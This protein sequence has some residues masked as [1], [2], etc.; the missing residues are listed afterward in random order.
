MDLSKLRNIGII[1]HVDAGKTTTTE[2]ILFYTGKSH[3][4]GEV[5]DGQA[6]MD[7]MEQEQERGITITSAATTCYWRNCQINI[8]DTPGHVDFTA[9][10]Q[11]SL[12][13]LDGAVGIFCAVGGVEPQSET[14]WRQAEQYGVPR[15][16]F[17]NKMDRMGADF[18]GVVRQIEEKFGI[19]TAVLQLPIGKES[20][21]EGVI[22]LLKMKELH[23]SKEDQGQTITETEIRGTLAKEASAARE[24]LFDRLTELSDEL[25]EIVLE[26][27]EPPSDL[28]REVI[29]KGV[30]ERKILPILAGSS[31]KNI[32][33]QPLLDAIVDYLP[34][35]TDVPAPTAF[36]PK[37]ESEETV[38]CDPK[39]P[40]LALI[41]KIQNDREAG[42]LSFVRV[43]SGIIK[44]GTAPINVNKNQKERITRIL[45]MHANKS[46]AVEALE[47]GDIGVLIGCKISQTGDTLAGE[48]KKL[49]LEP[50]SFP[51][52]VISVAIEPKTASDG[53][54]LR[55]ALEALQTEDPTFIVKENPET[56]Q[57]LISGMGE[58]HLDVITTRLLNEYK[59]AAN[60][61]NPQV[62]YRESI[63][64]TVSHT[65]T[66]N[67]MIAGKENRAGLTLT[68][69]PNPGK[70]NEYVC[71]ASVRSV[72]EE[73]AAAV[74]NGIENA[75]QSGISFGYPCIDIKA[76]VTEIDFSEEFSTPFAFEACAVQ[77]FDN[78]CRSASP[79]IMEPIMKIDVIVPTERV[80]EVIGSLT[81]KGGIIN[82]IDSHPGYECISGE[83]ALVNM[84][85]YSTVLRSLTQGRGTFGMEFSH[86]RKRP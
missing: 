47:A 49:L 6:T 82:H 19:S 65:E 13:V 38:P 64:K 4:I 39:G 81:S 44:K 78:A 30:A 52:P 50:P 29:R 20:E 71:E 43:Y 36:N 41:F 2:R 1:A 27:S 57:L 23:F 15:I 54:K 26:G 72:P 51:E 80:G 68:V 3:K 75:F 69:T 24:K 8:I 40:P 58:L 48:G 9:E 76:V 53:D 16:A 37:K 61:G 60:I 79:A 86:Y 74:K 34:C 46:E 59:A 21:F 67:R 35:P 22:D 83:N 18:A 7:W 42:F 85:G 31:L 55:K 10:V 14:V 62:S 73:I 5:D 77:A 25:M 45:R 11:R 70:G 33:A 12:R 84:F 66:F 63:E 32:G 56:G 28:V 17:V